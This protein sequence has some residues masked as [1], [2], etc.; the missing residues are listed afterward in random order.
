MNKLNFSE[1]VD[2]FKSKMDYNEFVDNVEQYTDLGTI[3]KVFEEFEFSSS[4][5]KV[6]FFEE[7]DIYIQIRGHYI[8]F[9]D[10]I[11]YRSS[12]PQHGWYYLKEVRPFEIIK[13]TYKIIK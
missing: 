7:H 12:I 13:T 3:K 8:N 10:K 1:I 4:P 11:S 2:H 6:I 5:I 9:E